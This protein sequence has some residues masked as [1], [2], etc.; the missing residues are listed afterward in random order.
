MIKT[1][2]E[3]ICRSETRGNGVIESESVPNCPPPV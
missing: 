3:T 1:K 2:T